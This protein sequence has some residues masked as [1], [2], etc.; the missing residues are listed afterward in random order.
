MR[1]ASADS[2]VHVQLCI[3]NGNRYST[4]CRETGEQRAELLTECEVLLNQKG[5]PLLV[6]A[7]SAAS[8]AT[9]PRVVLKFPPGAA[10]VPLR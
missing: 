4:R 3:V 8:D 10:F 1:I 6:A 7:G 2:A 9:R 5:D